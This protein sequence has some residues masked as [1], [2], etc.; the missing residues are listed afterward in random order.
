MMGKF[1]VF[2]GQDCSGKT[3]QTKLLG[4][5]LEKKGEKVLSTAFPRRDTPVGRLINSYLKGNESLSPKVI[6]LLFCANRWEVHKE[7][8]SAF[9]KRV[10]GHPRQVHCIWSCLCYS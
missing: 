2:E 1:I 8:T 4:D 10:L 9:A 3:T 7:I 6:H 5:H